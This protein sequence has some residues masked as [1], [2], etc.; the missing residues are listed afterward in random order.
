M[1]LQLGQKKP[2]GQRKLLEIRGARFLGREPLEKLAPS[3]RIFLTGYGDHGAANLAVVE[4][5][6]YPLRNPS[7]SINVVL[8]G[9]P[10]KSP[11]RSAEPIPGFW[12]VP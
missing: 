10:Q 9:R 3:A 6:G 2:L 4:L 11:S 12:A 7:S 1:L 5:N 8:S